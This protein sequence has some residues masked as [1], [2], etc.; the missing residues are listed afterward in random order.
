ME[1]ESLG[2]KVRNTKRFFV[3]NPTSVAYEFVWEPVTSVAPGEEFTP[4]RPS[5]FRCLN[6]R[7]VIAAGEEIRD[8]F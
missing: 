6:H 1:F 8:G 2:T 4:R 7:G 5:A 3:L